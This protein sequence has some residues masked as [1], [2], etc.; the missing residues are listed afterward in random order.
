MDTS[1]PYCHKPLKW[2]LLAYSNTQGPTAA[3]RRPTVARCPYC[4]GA[5]VANLHPK[6]QLLFSLSM[7]ALT[8]TVVA[9]LMGG[10]AVALVVAVASFLAMAGGAAYVHAKYL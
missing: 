9:A 4:G 10:T 2:K 7:V 8:A 1:C 6:E 5:L 3:F